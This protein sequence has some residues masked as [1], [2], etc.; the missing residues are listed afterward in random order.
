MGHARKILSAT[1]LLGM[2]ITAQAQNLDMRDTAPAALNQA[3]PQA[4]MSQASVEARY[5][6]PSAK[7]VPVGDPPITRWEYADFIVYFEYDKVIH[8]VRKR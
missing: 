8:A 5:G 4:G 7:R 3:G 1:A 2:A 6:A